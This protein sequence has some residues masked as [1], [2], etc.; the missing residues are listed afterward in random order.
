M[1]NKVIA[2][3]GMPGSGKTTVSN[4]LLEN[5]DNAVYFDFGFL[6]RPLTYYLVNELNLTEEEIRKLV[7]SKKLEDL[8]HIGYKVEDK[9][10]EISINS[11]FYTFQQLNTLQMNLDTV[12]VGSIIGDD[13]TPVLGNIVNDLKENYNVIIN[14]R[15]PVEAYPKLDNHIFLECTFD[16]RSKRKMNMNN[17][18]LEKTKNKLSARDKKEQES[19]FWKVYDFTHIIDTTNLSKEEVYQEVVK[20]ING[21]KNLEVNLNNLT[22]IL[23][24]Y[25]CNKNCPF[26]IAKNNQKFSNA[27]D[28]LETLSDTFKSLEQ[29]NITFKRFVLSGNGEPSFYSC[30]DLK[31]I[32]EALIKHKNLFKNFRSHSSGNVFFAEDKF[33]ILNDDVIPIEFEILRVDLD[34]QIDSQVLGYDKNYLESP[35]FNKA[36]IVKCDIA[37]TDYLNTENLKERL[38]EFLRQHPSIKTVRFKKLLVGDDDT[39]KQGTWTRAH[40]LNDEQIDVIISS[41]GLIP[42]KDGYTS[43]D[44]KIVY[45]P[46]GNYDEDKDIVINNG[47]IGDYN[48]NVYTVKAL[49]KK[50]G[51]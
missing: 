18:S 8:I 1:K 39:T 38:E 46:N 35:L 14:A 30:E 19:G 50:Y 47:N 48:Y 36:N 26:C 37:L 31:T 41:L 24:S 21:V 22:L 20:E 6:F 28:K 42:T 2:I 5:Y 10:V 12:M 33:E 7:E 25:R 3:S 11:K 17:E 23:G 29:A 9:K 16:E 43:Q 32:K 44:R 40:A 13:L 51:K 4:K 27:S 15:R 49:V 45:K 34:P